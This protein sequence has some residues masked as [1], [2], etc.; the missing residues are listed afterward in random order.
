MICQRCGCNY[1]FFFFWTEWQHYNRVY[2]SHDKLPTDKL[3]SVWIKHSDLC[4]L[5]THMCVLFWKWMNKECLYFYH[6]LKQRSR[7][8]A[9]VLHVNIWQ[10][11][12][13]LL[14]VRYSI[15][16]LS[17]IFLFSFFLSC[18]AAVCFHHGPGSDTGFACECCLHLQEPV[19]SVT[20]HLLPLRI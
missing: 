17:D 1:F 15:Y 13:V 3:Q 14:C 10:T 16:Y 11:L 8:S 20:F 12:P 18:L 19:F 5:K 7:Q 4:A 9:G 6:I 2:N